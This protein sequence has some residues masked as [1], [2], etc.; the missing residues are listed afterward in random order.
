MPA[1]ANEEVA[2]RL[3]QMSCRYPEPLLLRNWS[4]MNTNVMK[5]LRFT[6]FGPPSV[7]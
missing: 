1:G 3:S 5:S 4:A 7:L 2:E 6:E